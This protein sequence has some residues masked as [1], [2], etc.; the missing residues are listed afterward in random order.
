RERALQL[1]PAPLELAPQLVKA[2]AVPEADHRRSRELSQRDDLEAREVRVAR[3]QEH[4]RIPHDP[5][6]GERTGR[7]GA[8]RE[9]DVELGPRSKSVAP[10]ARSSAAICWLIADCV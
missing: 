3:H 5:D 2:R 10:T 8:D 6:R 7:D 1:D 9:R 4:V